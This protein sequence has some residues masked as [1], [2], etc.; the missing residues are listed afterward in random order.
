MRAHTTTKLALLLSLLALG[1]LGLI[2]CGG[3]DDEDSTTKAKV[4]ADTTTEATARPDT[5]TE[6]KLSREQVRKRLAKLSGLSRE[7]VQEL[8]REANTEAKLSREQVQ[9]L[10]RDANDWASRFAAH[11]CN[12]Y[13]GQ[14]MC[15]RL[16]CVRG[17]GGPPIENCTPVSAAFR[18]SFAGATVEDIRSARILLVRWGNHPVYEA[19]VK[20]SNGE[21]ALFDG[22][23][24]W[25]SCAGAG[26]GCTWSIAEHNRRFVEAAAPRGA[27]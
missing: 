21:V 16:A 11:A 17:P 1:A 7:Q 4:S 19:A 24:E 13:E 6:A 23:T 5:T 15:E 26:S 10:K 3:G 9:E 8:K 18:E 2:A 12:K 22:G 27:G 14:P 20:F 25:F